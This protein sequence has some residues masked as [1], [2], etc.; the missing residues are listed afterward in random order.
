MKRSTLGSRS[1]ALADLRRA[2]GLLLRVESVS[3][4]P[5]IGDVS[6]TLRFVIDAGLANLVPPPTV[7]V[8]DLQGPITT[9]PA[10]VTICLY[11]VIEDPSAKNRPRRRVP[12]PAGTFRI[13][14]APMALLLR[15]LVTPWSG[16]RAADHQILGR[17]MQILYDGAIIHGAAL[18]GGLA[19]TSE[20]LKITMSPIPLQERFWLWQAV[21]KAYR[22]SVTY[23][24]RV[25]NLDAIEAQ[26]VRPVAARE[27]DFHVPEPS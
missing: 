6:E 15:Y 26:L 24:V 23:E 20:A 8:H 7:E 4:Y 17:V 22:I 13:E 12:G 2:R 14:K 5:V 10:H 9:A 16:T 25:V 18:Q 21:Q 19:G 1:F 27:L 3:D 11:D